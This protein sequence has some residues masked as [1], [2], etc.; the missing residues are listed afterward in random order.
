MEGLKETGSSAAVMIHLLM[1]SEKTK[2][3]LCCS[4]FTQR[5]NETTEF[6]CHHLQT[7]YCDVDF[8]FILHCE[9]LISAPPRPAFYSAGR[10]TSCFSLNKFKLEKR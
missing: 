1:L 10:S 5:F 6:T 7:D 3:S 9:L 4:C 2:T 8:I